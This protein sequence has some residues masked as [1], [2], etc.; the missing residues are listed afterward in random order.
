MHT[1]WCAVANDH[2]AASR[3]VTCSS[4]AALLGVAGAVTAAAAAEG[5]VRRGVRSVPPVHGPSGQHTTIER[6]NGGGRQPEQTRDAAHAA[7]LA[8]HREQR[9][10]TTDDR[11]RPTLSQHEGAHASIHSSEDLRLLTGHEQQRQAERSK[12]DQAHLLPRIASH[13][14]IRVDRTSAVKV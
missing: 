8:P 1:Q 4:S 12:R 6:S 5:T 13:S 7:Q 10:A 14:S 11:R 9:A 2:C 3:A